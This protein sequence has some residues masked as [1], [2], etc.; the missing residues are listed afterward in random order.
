MA[1]SVLFFRDMPIV[2]GAKKPKLNSKNQSRARA[3]I[4]GRTSA[5]KPTTKRIPTTLAIRLDQRVTCSIGYRFSTKR[6]IWLPMINL[7]VLDKDQMVTVEGMNHPDD[8]RGEYSMIAPPPW[9][10]DLGFSGE[11]D[12]VT[13]CELPEGDFR[14]RLEPF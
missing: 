9:V 2:L 5:T 7:D 14:K 1:T 4:P 3:P 11:V 13:G 6:L 10:I 8:G 12:N